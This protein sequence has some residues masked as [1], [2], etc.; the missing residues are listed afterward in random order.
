[1]INTKPTYC[2]VL[3][4][5]LF[6]LT[7]LHSNGQNTNFRLDNASISTKHES[8]KATYNT[9]SLADT[10]QI[11]LVTVD[12]SQNKVMVVWDKP[13]S[14]TIDSFRIYKETGGSYLQI[15]SVDYSSLSKFTD[16]TTNPETETAKYKI[17]TLDTDGTEGALTSSYHS[18]IYAELK[19]TLNE[20]QL[21]WTTYTGFQ[22]SKYYI[23]LN[24]SG[25]SNNL[26]L[27][28][29]T[30]SPNTSWTLTEPNWDVNDNSILSHDI[31]A[32]ANMPLLISGFG[33]DVIGVFYTDTFGKLKCGGK[34]NALIPFSVW[35]DDNST[36]E[37]DGFIDGEEMFFKVWKKATGHVYHIDTLVWDT[38][39]PFT[40]Y[41]NDG[42]TSYITDMNSI[43]VPPTATPYSFLVKAIPPNGPCSAT[44]SVDF[45]CSYSNIGRLGNN[46]T[47]FINLSSTNTDMDSCNGSATIS[48]THGNPPYMYQWDD[49]VNQT[50][51]TAINLCA[52]TYTAMV[53]DAMG[54]SE[55]A[56][57]TVSPIQPTGISLLS[58]EQHLI[59]VYPNP[60]T[61]TLV[62]EGVTG[63]IRIYDIQNRLLAIHPANAVDL[64][65]FNSGLYYL[66]AMDK[67]GERSKFAR[68][69]KK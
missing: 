65:E 66:V 7:S 9:K 23:Y 57:I 48:A 52:G 32:N 68:I 67:N 26:E 15:G 39:L 54:F 11:C 6:Q 2:L 4:C 45:D 37:K 41:F 5:L 63:K 12:T 14:T 43:S 62:L 53:T 21:H 47:L 51:A 40:C 29:S 33:D 58:S 55:S 1:M 46:Q 30:A 35:G 38:A 13:V 61:G 17:T 50:T 19:D 44:K 64:T 16:P 28:D 3:L 49:P 25:S 20:L 59:K 31:F 22:T 36:P 18:P 42:A 34:G 56:S 27:I 69:I 8:N 24:D 10:Q 60:T